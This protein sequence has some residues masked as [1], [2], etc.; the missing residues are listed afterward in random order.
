MLSKK[1]WVFLLILWLFSQIALLYFNGITIV[2][3]S[4]FIKAADEIGA[5]HWNIE[6]NNYL[7]LGNIL[8]I[9]FFK[10]TGIS[11]EWIYLVQLAVGFFASICFVKLL[12]QRIFNSLSVMIAAFLFISCPF[13]QSWTSFLSTDSIFANLLVIC[14]YLMMDAAP[15][16]KGKAWLSLCL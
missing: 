6:L 5:G 8:I 10:L 7:Y 4:D 15:S 11:Y 2:G 1:Q 13:F 14:L 12:E 9:L 16:R 3:E